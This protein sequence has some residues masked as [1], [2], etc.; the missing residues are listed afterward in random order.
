MMVQFAVEDVRRL[1]AKQR[2]NSRLISRSI[3]RFTDSRVRK[4]RGSVVPIEDVIRANTV[5]LSHAKTIG[6]TIHGASTVLRNLRQSGLDNVLVITESTDDETFIFYADPGL[7]RLI[8]AIGIPAAAE[9]D[10]AAV[11]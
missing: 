7:K 1:L 6:L 11:S 10:A 8:A 9:R 5:R 3:G 2:A 4:V